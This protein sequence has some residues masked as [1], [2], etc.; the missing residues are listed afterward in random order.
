M[1]LFA[2][3]VWALY[4]SVINLNTGDCRNKGNNDCNALSPSHFYPLPSHTYLPAYLIYLLPSH[5]CPI[6]TYLPNIY[7]PMYPRSRRRQQLEG[8]LDGGRSV[9]NDLFHDLRGHRY[10]VGTLQ[11]QHEVTPSI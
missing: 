7:L 1:S 5:S 10:H 6:L 11:E 8:P 9:G 4:G 3:I 2:T